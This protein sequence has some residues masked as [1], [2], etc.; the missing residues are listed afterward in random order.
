[1][2]SSANRSGAPTKATTNTDG[3]DGSLTLPRKVSF[4]GPARPV[5]ITNISGGEILVNVNSAAVHLT[6]RTDYIV[7]D[8]TT[9]DLSIHGIVNIE[10]VNFSTT[11]SFD[12]D[13][14]SVVGW[15]L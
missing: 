10:E 12:L 11:G 8:D 5:L 2:S 14:V 4:D 9:F 1:M 15:V 3:T 7:E 6:T 13:A